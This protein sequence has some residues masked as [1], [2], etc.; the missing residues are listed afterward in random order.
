MAL[1]LRAPK[2][3]L[4]AHAARGSRIWRAGPEPS[5]CLRIC[6]DL[7]RAITSGSLTGPAPKLNKLTT[8]KTV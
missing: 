6:V 8:T 7:R 5:D 2:G 4:S 3:L 1:A